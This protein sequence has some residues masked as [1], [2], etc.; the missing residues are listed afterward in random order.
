MTKWKNIV[1]AFA[2]CAS[3]GSFLALAQP[4]QGQNPPQKQPMGFFVTSVGMTDGGNLGGLAG[5]DA[6]CQMLAEAAGSTGKTWHAYLST[7]ATGNQPAINARDR[8][9]NG[10][11]F[12]HDGYMIAD[13]VADLHGDTVE[14]ALHD[15]MTKANIVNEKGQ[16]ISPAFGE[17]GS[18]HEVLTGTDFDGRAFKDAADHTCSNW[19]SDAATGSAKVGHGDRNGHASSSWNS[20]TQTRG[21]T[22]DA[23]KGVGS[24]GYLYCFAIN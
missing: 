17:T 21:C 22:P 5:A 13:N 23:V 3:V 16:M 8:I 9:G 14:A 20:A 15:K 2:L 6:H 7:Q 4:P 19:T 18:I 12:N 11:W 24:A 10:P 1:V